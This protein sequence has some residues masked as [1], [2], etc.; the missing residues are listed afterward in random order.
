[1]PRRRRASYRHVTDLSKEGYRPPLP[2]QTR[3][4]SRRPQTNEAGASG[5]PDSETDTVRPANEAL[6]THEPT[7]QLKHA[8]SPPP[9]RHA[10]VDAPSV[11]L[12]ADPSL[13]DISA[14]TSGRSWRPGQ[15]GV[16]Q[17][18]A[19][20]AWARVGRSR[21]QAH[22]LTHPFTRPDERGRGEAAPSAHSGLTDR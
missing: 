12:T 13:P 9:P 15:L 19:E 8:T 1:M 18:Q 21:T 22:S 5:A 14:E 6:R 16:K 20:V 11:P 4:V 2:H 7:R 3:T 17:A 10:S